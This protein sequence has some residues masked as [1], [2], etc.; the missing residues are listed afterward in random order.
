MGR[1]TARLLGLLCAAT[2]VQ[3]L[4]GAEA[5]LSFKNDIAPI[6]VESCYACHNEKTKKGKYDMSSFD[7]IMK[8]GRF[9]KPPPASWAQRRPQAAE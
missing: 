3:P 2:A 9:H 7:A 1:F 6:F 8:G 5:V 4:L